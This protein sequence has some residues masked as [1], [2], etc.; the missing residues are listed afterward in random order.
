MQP[1]RPH[2]VSRRRRDGDYRSRTESVIEIDGFD[3]SLC[4]MLR[5]LVLRVARQPVDLLLD[6]E[7]VAAVAEER[8]CAVGTTALLESRRAVGGKM[9]GSSSSFAGFS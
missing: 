9:A 1:G 5:S 3:S 4:E 8:R 2:S 7:S 6:A